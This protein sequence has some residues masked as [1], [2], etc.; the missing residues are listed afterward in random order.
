MEQKQAIFAKSRIIFMVL[1]I[2]LIE[3][4]EILLHKFNITAWPAMVCMILYF[5][6]HMDHRQIPHIVIGSAFGILNY[7][8]IN[9][10]IKALTPITGAFP[11]QLIYIAVFVAAIVLL[12][13]HIP[14]VFNTSAFLLFVIAS[15]A[16]KAVPSPDPLNWITVQLVG[17]TV[18]ILGVFAIQK[19]L[20]RFGLN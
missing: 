11:A 15:I 17:G 13:D 12:M 6:V 7:M 10:F 3:I 20:K 9:P 2:V 16:G 5:F 1:L 8:L 18:L 14:W 19:I 4:G